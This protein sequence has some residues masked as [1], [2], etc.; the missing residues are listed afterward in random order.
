MGTAS[1]AKSAS[2]SRS[3]RHHSPGAL[4]TPR[5]SQDQVVVRQSIDLAHRL[6]SFGLSLVTDERETLAQASFLILAEVNA[7]AVAYSISLA[8]H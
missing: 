6:L 4:T 2:E 1:D 3:Q 7:S 8:L 5:A